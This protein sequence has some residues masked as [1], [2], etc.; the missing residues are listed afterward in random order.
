MKK[1]LLF[2][3]VSSMVCMGFVSCLQGDDTSWRD[4]NQTYL[5]ETSKQEGIN[6]IGDT[7]NGYPEIYY[8]VIKQGTGERPVRGNVLNTAYE[9]WLYN[10]TIPFDSSDDYDYTLGTN[11]IEGWNIVLENMH[12]GDK[13]KVYIPY[14]LA[15]GSSGSSSGNVPAYSTLIFDIELKKIVSEN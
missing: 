2:L 10:D 8:K 1:Q 6:V 7:L 11:G 9:G 12:V 14:N 13:W 5:Q 3:L 15:Y 4:A